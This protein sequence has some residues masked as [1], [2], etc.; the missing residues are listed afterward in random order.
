MAS[1]RRKSSISTPAIT[2]APTTTISSTGVPLSEEPA[3]GRTR[4]AASPSKWIK[5]ANHKMF[6]ASITVFVAVSP[7]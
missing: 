6:P 7:V 1:E 4:I 3:F 5:P 2:T